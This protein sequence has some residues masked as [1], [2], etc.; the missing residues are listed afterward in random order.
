MGNRVGVFVDT[1][2]LFY[3]VSKKWAGRKVDYRELLRSSIE[4]REVH[5]A[6]AFGT[7]VDGAAKKFIKCLHHIG[8]ETHYR[9]IEKG[10]WYDW[11]V[12]IAI[13]MI[14]HH[15]KV[16]EVILGS[17]NLTMVPVVKWLR[18]NG[19]TVTVIACGIPRELK[20]AADSWTELTEDML[21]E[22]VDASSSAA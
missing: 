10:S 4:S 14:R 3:C 17:S 7:Q 2:N 12:G 18:E 5:R 1:G 20:E 8:F 19:V 13:E 11:A 16:D 21:E 6:F 15:S 22:I 9:D